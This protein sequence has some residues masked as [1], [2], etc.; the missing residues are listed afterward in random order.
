MCSGP[1]KFLEKK[2]SFIGND[3]SFQ[4]P[5]TVWHCLIHFRRKLAKPRR[6][7]EELYSNMICSVEWDE[8]DMEHTAIIKQSKAPGA[9]G[10]HVFDGRTKSLMM[11]HIRNGAAN[12]QESQ[13][14]FTIVLLLTVLEAFHRRSVSTKRHIFARGMWKGIQSVLDKKKEKEL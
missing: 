3:R 5:T 6:I 1:N 12:C 2:N 14:I 7:N 10:D 13:T 4:I 8:L 11:F 9:E